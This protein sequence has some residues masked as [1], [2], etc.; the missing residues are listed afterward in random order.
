M[1]AA[2]PN[3]K[4]QAERCSGIRCR[5]D[6]QPA[7][8]GVAESSAPRDNHKRRW[9]ALDSR[10]NRTRCRERAPVIPS[11]ARKHFYSND[12]KQVP[13]SVFAPRFAVHDN[14]A[15]DTSRRNSSLVTT[16]ELSTVATT[17]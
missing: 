5:S 8:A 16:T 12:K 4:F 3:R 1:P 13:M 17:S 9:G 14:S 10:R 2:D 7:R 15:S 6:R 11:G